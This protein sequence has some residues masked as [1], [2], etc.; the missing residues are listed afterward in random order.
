MPYGDDPLAHIGGVLNALNCGAA[1]ID[2]AGALVY[3]NPRLCQMMRRSAD[4]LVGANLLEIYTAA[5]DQQAVR[6]MLENF[7]EKREGEFS[8]PLPDGSRV[9]VVASSRQLSG[10]PPASDHRVITL[11][12]ISQQKD[13]ERALKEHYAFVVQMSDTVLNQAVELKDYNKTLEAK[14]RERTAELHAANLDAIY[15]LAVAAEAKDLDTGKHVRRIQ[16]YSRALSMQLGMSDADAETIGYA[17]ILHDVGKIHIPDAIL[18]KPGPLT[19][20]ERVTMQ[21]HTVVGERILSPRPF[22]DQARQIAR[23]HHE[24]W[25]SSGYPDHLGGQEIPLPARIVHVVD[26]YDAL[27]SKR[28]YKEAWDPERAADTLLEMHGKMFD[29]EIAK[30]FHSLVSNGNLQ[31]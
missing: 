19:V 16:G 17:A 20:E 18:N 21:E 25:D 14:V 9:P 22:F 12:D 3:V 8:L 1:L 31:K 11:I 23:W 2:R 27:T 28:V 24:N 7:G 6:E 26:V 13:A 15:M 4:E 29:P 10:A 30:A 5:A